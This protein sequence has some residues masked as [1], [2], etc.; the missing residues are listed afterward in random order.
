MP[1]KLNGATNG[2]VELDVPA[3]VGSDLQVTL[4]ATA[5]TAIVK[6]TDGSVDLGSVDIDSSGNVGIGTSS[7]AGLIHC[8]STTSIAGAVLSTTAGSDA[9]IEFRNTNGGNATWAAGLDFSNSKSF[10]LAYAAAEG[11]S[12]SGN[13]LLTVTTGGNVG[14]GTSSPS[15]KLHIAETNGNAKL[16]LQRTN[17]A[18]N[19]NDYGTILWKSTSG[20]NNGLIGV[21]RETGEDNGYMFFQTASGGSLS[22]RMRIESGGNTRLEIKSGLYLHH[23]SSGAGN[24]TL[25]YGTSSGLVSFDTSSRLVKEQIIDCP[26]G[27][28]KLKQLQPRKYFRTDDQAEEIGFI[29]DELVQVM[30]E[31]VPIGP[32]S[33]IT[34]NEDDTEEIPLG[35]N[36][37]KLTSVLTKALQEAIAKIETLETKVAALEA[38]P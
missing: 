16:T 38:A 27:I 5:G 35:V 7:P 15:S 33:V 21:A 3:A 24:S 29:A 20:N 37:E 8:A 36:Y 6:A 17:S 4:P 9:E 13:S 11:A 14:I 10:N 34:K 28:D 18:S 22:E 32:K 26:Y 19:T 25:K 1:I 12:L 2:S 31:F 23:L 30:P